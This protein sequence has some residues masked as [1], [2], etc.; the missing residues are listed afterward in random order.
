MIVEVIS[1]GT[2][3]LLGQIV[4]SNAAYIGR[5]L[6]EDGFDVNH[7][8]AVGDNLGRLTDVIRTAVSRA[9]AVVLTGGIGPTQDDMTREAL[10]IVGE[11]EMGRDEEHASWI[12]SRVRSQGREPAPNVV[13][14]AEIPEGAD[15]LPNSNGVALGVAM[16]HEGTWMFAVPGVPV[17]MKAMFEEQVLPRLRIAAGE[18]ATLRSR[19]L[20]CWGTGESDIAQVIGDL[21]ATSNPSVAFLISDMEV[22]IR[23]SAK[24]ATEGDAMTLIAPIEAEVR[25][26]L[27]EAVFATDDETV[28]GI[29]VERLGVRGW[30]VATIEEATLGQVGGHLAR[31]AGGSDIYAATV[32][33]G[34]GAFGLTPRADVTLE[35][36]P[37]G[38]DRSWGKRTTR[39]V[40]MAVHTPDTTRERVFDLGGDDERVRAFATLAALHMIRLAVTEQPK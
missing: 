37:I 34:S 33:P 31:A 10:C 24:A 6:A 29:V 11:R 18:P 12:V 25:A 26:R 13:R 40:R 36:G 17:E 2:E 20:K 15:A 4:N 30:T 8:V 1:V 27:G 21:F 39:P 22:K 9:D 16:Q 38:D 7:Q 14:M 28:E 19:V 5:R 3:L 32:I 35:V 23:I